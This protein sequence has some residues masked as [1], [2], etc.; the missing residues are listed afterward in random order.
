LSCEGKERRGQ[1]LLWGKCSERRVKSGSELA[2]L[3][4]LDGVVASLLA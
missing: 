4:T 2:L 3:A 1:R